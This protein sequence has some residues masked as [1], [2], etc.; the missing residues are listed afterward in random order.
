VAGEEATLV[1]VDA[2]LVVDNPSGKRDCERQVGQ[3]YGR[4]QVSANSTNEASRHRAGVTLRQLLEQ[5][6]WSYDDGH[7]GPRGRRPY[8][9]RVLPVHH[10]GRR[11]RAP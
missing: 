10:A 7:G 5:D 1:F 8:R 4:W 6:G 3:R 2:P 9:I 11:G